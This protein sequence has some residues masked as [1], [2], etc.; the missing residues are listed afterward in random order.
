MRYKLNVEVRPKDD[1][2]LTAAQLDEIIEQ[3]VDQF[4]TELELAR[5]QWNSSTIE[6]QD[7]FG[8]TEKRLH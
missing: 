1:N 2:H 7:D 5:F 6:R 8:H 3:L 4:E